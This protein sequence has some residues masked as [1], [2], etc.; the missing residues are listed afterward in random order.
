MRSLL[1]DHDAKE[2]EGFA[3]DIKVALQVFKVG[4]LSS[5]EHTPIT[6]IMN[7]S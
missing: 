4:D 2:L 6:S 7:L 1:A 3:N 5:Y